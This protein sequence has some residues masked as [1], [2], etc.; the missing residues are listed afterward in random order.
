MAA[1]ALPVALRMTPEAFA[2][3]LPKL[4]LDNP[5]A[6]ALGYTED[7]SKS[8]HPSYKAGSMCANCQFFTA[9]TGAC[10]LFQGFS[11]SPKGWCSAWAKKAG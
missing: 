8:K 9:A 6:K 5:Q 10:A 4:P 11:V 2:A 1:A 3:G 7:A